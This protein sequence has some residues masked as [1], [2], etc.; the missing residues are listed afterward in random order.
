[1]AEITKDGC[2]TKEGR[3][4]FVGR[5]SINQYSNRLQENIAGHRTKKESG[6][7]SAIDHRQLRQLEQLHLEE[8]ACPFWKHS[9]YLL[10]QALLEHLHP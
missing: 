6:K 1:M 2:R 3:Q 9:Q 10:R 8:Q 5:N 7:S 4:A